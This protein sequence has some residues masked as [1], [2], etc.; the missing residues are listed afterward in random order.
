MFL[1][2]LN[3]TALQPGQKN[4]PTCS[5]WLNFAVENEVVNTGGAQEEINSFTMVP[6]NHAL[7][8]RSGSR[9]EDND[10]DASVDPQARE[11]YLY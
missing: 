8:Y 9:E 5:S 1:D 7:I 6:I 3:I 4:L 2:I 11:P 10:G